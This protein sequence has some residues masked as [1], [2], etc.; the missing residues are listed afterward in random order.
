GVAAHVAEL[1]KRIPRA[2]LLV[3]IDEPMLP[4]VLQGAIPTPS[5]LS[6]VRAVEGEVARERLHTVLAATPNYTV[7]HCCSGE[8]P[9]GIIMDAGA[10]G[11]SFDPSQLRRGD[12][13]GFA[14]T[15]EAGAGLLIGALPTTGPAAPQ[16]ALRSGRDERQR[17]TPSDTAGI[18]RDLW[19]KMDL[20]AAQCAP[21]VV[22]TPACGLP[23]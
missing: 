12:F 9:F 1:S 3:Q 10:D 14:E 23:G 20:P 21:Q 2:T 19:R 7:V 6:R 8:L 13:D 5:G 18:V 22:I 4:T 17:P 11:V 15:A 16:V